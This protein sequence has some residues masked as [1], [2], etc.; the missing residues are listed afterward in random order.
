MRREQCSKVSY[1][2]PTI[3][4]YKLVKP[5]VVT[6]WWFFILQL[7]RVNDFQPINITK[8]FFVVGNDGIAVSQSRGGNNGIR[9]FYFFALAQVYTLGNHIC[10]RGRCPHRT[11]SYEPAAKKIIKPSVIKSRWFFNVRG[12]KHC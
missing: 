5:S 4:N 1:A 11:L 2:L 9:R 3:T 7:M 10:P 6:S 12:S 8:I